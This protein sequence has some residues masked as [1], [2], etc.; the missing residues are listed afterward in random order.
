MSLALGEPLIGVAAELTVT[1]DLSLA[2][3]TLDTNLD[4]TRLDRAGG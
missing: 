4:I 3:G 2:D 1:G